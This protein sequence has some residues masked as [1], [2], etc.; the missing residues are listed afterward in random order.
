MVER[1]ILTMKCL[2]SCLPL[3]PYRREGFQRELDALAQWYNGH[4]PHTWLDG[5]TPDEAYY[6]Q[7]AANRKPR[8]E[9]RAR[10]PRGSPSASP[11][12]LVS[13]KPGARL[14]LEVRYHAGRRHVPI[15]SLRRVA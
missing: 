12:A 11:H 15:V 10:W 1:F 5:K 14:E 8:Y 6:G 7:H 4:R 9:P 2:L 3:V 13:G